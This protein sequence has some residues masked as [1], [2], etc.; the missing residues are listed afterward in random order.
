MH[1]V[2]LTR[3]WSAF[4]VHVCIVFCVFLRGFRAGVACSCY[5][6]GYSQGYSRHFHLRFFFAAE[7]VMKHNRQLDGSALSHQEAISFPI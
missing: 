1:G 2:S 6:P 4:F 7:G 3:E 5:S